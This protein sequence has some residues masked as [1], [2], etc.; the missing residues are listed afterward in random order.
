MDTFGMQHEPQALGG[1]HSAFGVHTLSETVPLSIVTKLS[2]TSSGSILIF[3]ALSSLSP[4]CLL[5]CAFNTKALDKYHHR[6]A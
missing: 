3:R 1:G 4:L 6:Q 5:L 2:R